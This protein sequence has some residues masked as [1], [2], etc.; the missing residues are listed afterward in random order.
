MMQ[1]QYHLS[2]NGRGYDVTTEPYQTLLDTL[3]EGLGLTGSKKG[4]NE[5]ECASCTVLVDGMPKNSCLILIGDAVGKE[6]VTIEG[7]AASADRPHPIQEAMVNLGGAQCGYCTPGMIVSAFAL[8]HED[9]NPTDDD[10]KFYLAGNICRC[11]GYNKITAAVRS[12][13]ET[14]RRMS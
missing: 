8:L 3:R 6:I 4:C 12:A 10:I 9:P 7:L 2:I 5:G 13:A 1:R 14:M 11:T